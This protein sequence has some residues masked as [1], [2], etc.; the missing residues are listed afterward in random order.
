MNKIF[1]IAIAAMMLL[2]GL[3]AGVP[4]VSA[5]SISTP[6]GAIAN[7][8]GQW[9]TGTEN[10]NTYDTPYSRTE[11]S[12]Y[13]VENERLYL[14][15]YDHWED[16]SQTTLGTH[17]WV[18]HYIPLSLQSDV[19]IQ[20]FLDEIGTTLLKITISDHESPDNIYIAD[21]L[22]NLLLAY[23]EAN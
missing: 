2:V 9:S 12:Y 8:I 23:E 7:N 21:S 20:E 14:Y 22:G 3:L 10:W 15:K 6:G 17:T 16:E 19:N 13:I 18:Y 11:T 1:G 5:V 4:A